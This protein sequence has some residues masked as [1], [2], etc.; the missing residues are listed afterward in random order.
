MCKILLSFVLSVVLS[1]KWCGETTKCVTKYVTDSRNSIRNLILQ[2][3]VQIVVT[4]LLAS[5]AH[6]GFDHPL[7]K[8]F[9]EVSNKINET[10]PSESET[11][12]EQTILEDISS[13]QQAIQKQHQRIGGQV[14]EVVFYN[15]WYDYIEILLDVRTSITPLKFLIKFPSLHHLEKYFPSSSG[16]MSTFEVYK[17]FVGLVFERLELNKALFQE[18]S[19]H[20]TSNHLRVAL[21]VALVGHGDIFKPQ[22]PLSRWWGNNKYRGLGYMKGFWNEITEGSSSVTRD[23]IKELLDKDERDN[24]ISKIIDGD[25]KKRL[26]FSLEDVREL[27]LETDVYALETLQAKRINKKMEDLIAKIESLSPQQLRDQ[28]GGVIEEALSLKKD[29]RS[30]NWAFSKTQEKIT[31]DNSKQITAM[32]LTQLINDF[33]HHVIWAGFLKS[34]DNQTDRSVWGEFQDSIRWLVGMNQSHFNKDILPLGHLSFSY[35]KMLKHK[36]RDAQV[37][38]FRTQNFLNTKK[39]RQK[40]LRELEKIGYRR[41]LALHNDY[42]LVQ[43]FLSLVDTPLKASI[44]G[45]LFSHGYGETILKHQSG[46][47]K[48]ML[49]NMKYNQQN[50]EELERQ[51]SQETNKSLD[52][53]SRR[54][55][56]RSM[57]DLMELTTTRSAAILIDGLLDMSFYK[58]RTAMAMDTEDRR[59]FKE[60]SFLTPNWVEFIKQ[61]STVD[62]ANE[63]LSLLAEWKKNHSHFSSTISIQGENPRLENI[64]ELKPLSPNALLRQGLKNPDTTLKSL[65]CKRL[66]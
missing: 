1:I 64:E 52:F 5:V 25:I 46:V 40:E 4:T 62:Q 17:N 50:N 42:I 9:H 53:V 16:P 66:F 60:P 47:E 10:I 54:F 2:I 31:A 14:S 45:R 15:M 59:I 65:M 34:V 21:V 24:A 3:V 41:N 20:L 57:S 63:L 43:D 33:N 51:V 36:Y 38:S 49:L 7:S 19:L 61:L 37:P 58:I 13:L 32:E 44:A 8:M 12:L 29:L 6:G 55:I 18:H 27:W 23:L 26:H 11:I 48:L 39:E 56:T 22:Q 28:E 35:Y 30:F